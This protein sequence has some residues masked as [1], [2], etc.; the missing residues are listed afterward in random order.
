[1]T[2]K[3][4]TFCAVDLCPAGSKQPCTPQGL[5]DQQ[6]PSFPME[7]HSQDGAP[8]KSRIYVLHYL[9]NGPDNS[10]RPIIFSP[11]AVSNGSTF[12][13]TPFYIDKILTH[14]NIYSLFAICPFNNFVD[15]PM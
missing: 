5:A 10:L 6:G 12:S 2:H 9:F 1:M 7:D 14:F 8:A 13:C 4:L 11:T 3:Y 15:H